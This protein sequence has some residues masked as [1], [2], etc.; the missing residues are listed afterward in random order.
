[1]SD[2]RKAPC[3]WQWPPRRHQWVLRK[4]K[5]LTSVP[6]SVTQPTVWES[7]ECRNCAWGFKV[8]LR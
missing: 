8:R 1:M 4:R 6:S 5:W 3:W 7:Y 2:K